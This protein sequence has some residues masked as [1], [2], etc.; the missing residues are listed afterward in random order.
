MFTFLERL[1]DAKKITLREE[2]PFNGNCPVVLRTGDGYSVGRCE[3]ALYG[4]ICP[5]HGRL[6]GM[7]HL[8]EAKPEHGLTQVLE[9]IEEAQLPPRSERDF[10]PP[11][12]FSVKQR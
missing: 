6:T 12:L 5:S 3:H 4:D 10:G 8:R 2:Y 9:L 11:G 1:K 7:L